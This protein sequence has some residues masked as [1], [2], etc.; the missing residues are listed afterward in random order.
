MFRFLKDRYVIIFADII[1]KCITY[2]NF[3]SNNIKENNKI[4]SNLEYMQIFHLQIDEL[5]RRQFAA[6]RF[7]YDVTTVFL[8]AQDFSEPE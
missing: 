5:F 2:N 1:K 7:D 3:L 8:F 4:D 6:R